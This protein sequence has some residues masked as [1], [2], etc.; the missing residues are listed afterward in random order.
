LKGRNKQLENMYSQLVHLV[1]GVEEVIWIPILTSCHPCPVPVI[2][3]SLPPTLALGSAVEPRFWH[4]PLGEGW[5]GVLTQGFTLARH[6]L[7]ATRILLFLF[8]H[9]KADLLMLLAGRWS[10]GELQVSSHEIG[11]SG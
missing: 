7:L 5:T 2:H 6:L 3:I 10:A 9:E 1:E 11:Q 4:L 8:C